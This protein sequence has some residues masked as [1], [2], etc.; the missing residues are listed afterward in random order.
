MTKDAEKA[1]VILYTEHLRRRSFGTPK[2]VS[3]HFE[4]RKIYA[5]KDFSSWA[6]T[7][8]DDCLTELHRLGFLSRNILGDVTLLPKGIEYVEKQP[9][10]FFES[11]SGY[12]KDLLSLVAAFRP[13]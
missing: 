7:D 1:M 9:K 13:I 12:I 10:E 4:D 11:F 8:I 6:A 2:S 5:I 3:A